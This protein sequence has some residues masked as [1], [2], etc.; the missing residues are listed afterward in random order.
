VQIVRVANSDFTAALSHHQQQ[1]VVQVRNR[2]ASIEV[3]T[4]PHLNCSR[5]LLACEQIFDLHLLYRILRG[6]SFKID[7]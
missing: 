2:A 5:C 3:Y 7:S 4:N 6:G 1:V